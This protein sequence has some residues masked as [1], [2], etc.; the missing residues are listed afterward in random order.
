MD[1]GQPKN[2]RRM[3]RALRAPL[4][5]ALLLL[6][7]G[8]RRAGGEHDRR[9]HDARTRR[10]TPVNALAIGSDRCSLRQAVDKA[11]SGDTIQLPAGDYNLTLGSDIDIAK[12]LT[13]E[14]DTTSDTVIDGSQ[15]TDDNTVATA[16][17]LRVDGRR[18]SRSRT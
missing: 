18:P 10:R 4:L 2:T 16:R 6:A 8:D 14:G 13:I 11:A 9:Q 17:I 3:R 15:N 5:A 12:S 7:L 1:R